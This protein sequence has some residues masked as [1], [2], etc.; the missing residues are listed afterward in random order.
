MLKCTTDCSTRFLP[1]FPQANGAPLAFCSANKMF[2]EW[3][4][5]IFDIFVIFTKKRVG[6][7]AYFE[8]LCMKM[9]KNTGVLAKT[10]DILS[11]S[12]FNHFL[13]HKNENGCINSFRKTARN[14]IEQRSFEIEHNL[15]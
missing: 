14:P 4:I 2:R 9:S 13:D 10:Y 7:F 6:I 1:V 8:R 15:E 12:F 11:F 3:E 5:T